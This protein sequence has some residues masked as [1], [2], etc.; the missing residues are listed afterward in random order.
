M[1]VLEGPSLALP[2]ERPIELL[3]KAVPHGGGYKIPDGDGFRFMPWAEILEDVKRFAGGLQAIGVGPGTKVALFSDTRYEWKIIDQAVQWLGGV[4][5]PIYPTLMHDQV[6]HIMQDSGTKIGFVENQTLLD[7]V[8]A[9]NWYS[10][11]K[12]TAPDWQTLRGKAIEMA[13]IGL[14]E[15]CSI[16]Y[17]SGTTG[18][19]KGAVLTHRNWTASNAGNLQGLALYDHPEATMLAFLPLAHVAGYASVLAITALGGTI[20]FSH[21]SRIATDFPLVRPDFMV[22][23][24][25]IYERI[26]TK[27]EERVA[28]GPAVRRFLFARA[29]S[30]AIKTGKR[31]EDGKSPAF[32]HWLFERIVY[33]KLRNALG[34]DRV[35]VAL[36]GAAPVR[37]SLL[38]FFQGIG[39]NIV[40]AYGLT[41][42]AGLLVSNDF[43]QFKAG[44]VGKIMPGSKLALAEDGEILL[45]GPTIFQGYLSGDNDCLKDG[46]LYTGDLGEMR[47]G[48]LAVIDRKKEIEVLD[49]GKNVA[50]A[51]LEELLKGSPLVDEVCIIGQ[52]RKFAG[53]LIQPN[54]GFIRAK[55][56]ELGATITGRTETDP[57]GAENLVEVDETTLNDSRIIAWIQGAVDKVNAR[58]PDYEQIRSFKLVPT[59]FS[60]ERDELTP[61]FK[62]KRRN[63]IA[64]HKA[65]IEAIF[66]R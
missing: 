58:L 21:P 8:P 10:F 11:D 16:V 56:E 1:R 12:S 28:G 23:V 40:E 36:T 61:T 46:W 5:I 4:V 53:A 49:T 41:E 25:R 26:M 14:D 31:Q 59:A 18:P 54:F 27:V 3:L 35:E 66:Q 9:G 42:C 38:Y 22:A 29:K 45:A 39:V 57:T 48:F 2:E 30:V 44:T 6:K 7:R 62:K 43:D 65:R 24:P 19:P 37:P 50:P 20:V 63:I 51:H 60:V 15:P 34:F 33:K 64:N 17:T 52:G 13:E 47:D 32:G 55:L